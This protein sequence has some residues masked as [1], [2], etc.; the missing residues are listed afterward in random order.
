MSLVIVSVN[1]RSTM[2]TEP[3]KIYSVWQNWKEENYACNTTC[4]WQ[5]L[6]ADAV[7]RV[8]TEMISKV[9]CPKCDRSLGLLQNE[10]TF[11]EIEFFASQGA[12]E[13]ANYLEKRNNV[14]G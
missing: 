1:E 8:E 14:Q 10:A 7:F 3:R 6:G 2:S 4:G 9:R 11:E 12:K 13:A 5:G